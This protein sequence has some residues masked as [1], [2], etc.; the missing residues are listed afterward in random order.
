MEYLKSVYLQDM[1]ELQD[2]SAR[3]Q[4]YMLDQPSDN[5][6]GSAELWRWGTII[7]CPPRKLKG[8]TKAGPFHT[9]FG[10]TAVCQLKICLVCHSLCLDYK[11]D[12]YEDDKDRIG[13][14]TSDPY[15]M[16][17]SNEDFEG[18]PPSQYKTLQILVVA[19][20]KE[21]LEKT[22]GMSGVRQNY[23]ATFGLL[24]ASELTTGGRQQRIGFYKGKVTVFF[25][26][27]MG[28]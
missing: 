19:H 20:Q 15:Q 4:Q 11:D 18:N 3:Q 1:L 27:K 24:V 6:V 13:H 28:R 22:E 26:F 14:I 8:L 2:M 23:E 12:E 5:P 21:H 7:H 9:S 10:K 16:P 17:S 25:I